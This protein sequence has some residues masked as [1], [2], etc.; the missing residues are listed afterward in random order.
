MKTHSTQEDSTML[1]SGYS[2]ER[3]SAREVAGTSAPGGIFWP[4]GFAGTGWRVRNPQGEVVFAHAWRGQCL[5]YLE[6]HGFS[7]GV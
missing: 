2:L 4:T 1:G 7:V 6:A 5:E 3:Y